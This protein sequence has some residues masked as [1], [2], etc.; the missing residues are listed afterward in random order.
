MPTDRIAVVSSDGLNVD[1]H[2]GKARRFII[3][4]LNS[5]LTLV[6]ERPTETLSVGDP[7]HTFDADRFG[8]ISALLQDCSKVY[9]TRIGQVPKEKLLQMGVAPVI[10]QGAIADISAD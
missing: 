8:R 9:T 2:F 4:D 1:D 10:Y 5:N 7:N 6:E 3:F